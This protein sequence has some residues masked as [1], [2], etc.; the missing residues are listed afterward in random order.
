MTNP[1]AEYE[2]R[3][4]DRAA[5]LTE[6]DARKELLASLTDIRQVASGLVRDEGP[7]NAMTMYRFAAFL[8]VLSRKADEQASKNL[9]IQSDM[10][11]LTRQFLVVSIVLAGAQLVVGYLQL[12]ATNPPPKQQH[13]AKTQNAESLQQPITVPH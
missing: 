13:S 4:R 12:K 3:E 10:L 2:Q 8:A 5:K 11:R 7:T 6:E 9:R 1:Q